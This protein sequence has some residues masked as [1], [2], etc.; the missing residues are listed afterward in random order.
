MIFLYLEYLLTR[1]IVA[2]SIDIRRRININFSFT[3]VHVINFRFFELF[4]E[5]RLLYVHII[6]TNEDRLYCI[7]IYTI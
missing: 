4:S 7:Q 1:D 5:F 3:Y 6:G 2:G